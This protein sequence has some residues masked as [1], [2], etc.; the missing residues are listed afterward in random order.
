MRVMF[1]QEAR[2]RP[3]EYFKKQTVIAH[4][5]VICIENPLFKILVFTF[6]TFSG[7]IAAQDE[8]V[9][10]RLDSLINAERIDMAK[11]E[12]QDHF[13]AD[14]INKY[15][16]YY[17]GR[18]AKREEDLVSAKRYYDLCLKLDK[19]FANAYAAYAVV[20]SVEENYNKAHTYI[21]KAIKLNP[22]NLDY[23]NVR[24][25]LYYY[26]SN[27]VLAERDFRRLLDNKTDDPYFLYNY[28][29][30]L[31]R[32]DKEEEALHYFNLA[33]ELNPHDAKIYYDRGLTLYYLDREKEAIEDLNRAM[34]YRKNIHSYERPSKSAIY[35]Y[36]SLCYKS[37]EQP[38]PQAWFK[39]CS[40]LTKKKSDK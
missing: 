37:L 25:I 26:E 4:L 18:I 27:Y 34:K 7:I 31:F 1:K 40:L 38:I 6:L 36:K 8:I 21:E 17:K 16:Y 10:T 2:F 23:Y 24:G 30:L 9:Y 13:D 14:T 28:A 22:D 20:F 39:A 19:E 32:L 5:S 3:N 29:C 35:R 12:L 11:R 15:W 33:D